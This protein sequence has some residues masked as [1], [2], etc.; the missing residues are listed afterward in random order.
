MKHTST[1]AFTRA[2][3]DGTARAPL[4]RAV[5]AGETVVGWYQN[6]PPW[7]GSIV[8]F[9]NEAIYSSDGKRVARIAIH[10][11]RGYEDPHSKADVTGVRILTTKRS[12]F[13]RVAGSFGPNGNRKDAYSFIM[14]V[15]ALT[16]GIPIVRRGRNERG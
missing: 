10:D 9:T 14:V 13:V 2:E 12:R 6:P 8:V 5:R 3:G 7:S 11:I 16:P 15:R 1:G 4:E